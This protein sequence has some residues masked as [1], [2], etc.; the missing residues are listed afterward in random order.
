MPAAMAVSEWAARGDGP[1]TGWGTS[2]HVKTL[3]P[4]S[5]PFS[6]S[7]CSV[8]FLPGGAVVTNDKPTPPRKRC[9][10]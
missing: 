2:S 7:T 10:R 5:S 4:S 6:S 9:R 1:P 8:L 3:L